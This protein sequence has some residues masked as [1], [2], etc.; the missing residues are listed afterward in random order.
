[1]NELKKKLMELF[2][3]Q[4]SE[5]K[6]SSRLLKKNIVYHLNDSNRNYAIKIFKYGDDETRFFNELS[7]YKFFENKKIINT[8]K[9]IDCFNSEFGY[10]LVISWLDGKSLKQLLKEN[11]FDTEYDNI[12]NM[13]HDMEKI[14]DTSISQIKFLKV[15]QLGISKRLN[16]DLEEIMQQICINK[17]HINFKL[18]FD[19]YSKLIGEINPHFDYLINSDVSAH[20]YIIK[21]NV[22]YWI[23][24]EKFNIGDP[25]NDLA[26]LF[27]SVSNT[28]N[29]YENI[30]K[31][32]V[33]ICRNKYFDKG[34]FLYYLTEKLMCSIHDAPEQISDQEIYY[35]IEFILSKMNEKKKQR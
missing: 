6:L 14:W 12:M 10:M 21:D 31:L 23:D 15:D 33:I 26:R 18:L 27:Q 22:G 20:E 4:I 8:P 17:P 29:K 1:M 16:K 28:F 25:N 19:T 34:V 35:Y 32:Y 7:M 30:E 13:I 9:L 2:H 11:N 24:F 3:C 5:L